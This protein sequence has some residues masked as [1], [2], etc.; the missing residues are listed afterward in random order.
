[1][2]CNRH[3]KII[4]EIVQEYLTSDSNKQKISTAANLFSEATAGG[5]CRCGKQDFFMQDNYDVISEFMELIVSW[6]D[7]F[8]I[9]IAN[10]YTCCSITSTKKFRGDS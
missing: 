8:I 4:Y 7:I 5:A 1:V 10:G 3:L 9:K 6:V 2:N